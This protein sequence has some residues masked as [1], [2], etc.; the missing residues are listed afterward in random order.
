MSRGKFS[1]M[2]GYARLLAALRDEPATIS[3]F[4]A[5]HG[6]SYCGAYAYIDGL[7]QLGRVHIAR[8]EIASRIRPLAVYAFGRGTDAPCPPRTLGGRATKGG[9][10]RT[11]RAP[12]ATLI[13]LDYLLREVELHPT[14]VHGLAEVTGVQRQ[15]LRRT[16]NQLLADRLIH[17][18]EWDRSTSR[19]P[20]PAYSIGPG[21]NATRPRRATRAETNAKY[22][23][24]RAQRIRYAALHKAI[25]A[26]PSSP[27][28][29]A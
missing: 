2:R 14:T 12:S 27:Q 24:S 16:V 28:V 1:G 20:I 10:I 7:H 13:A 25:I 6:L 23:A 5:R 3:Q 11:G 26:P 15:A 18:G 22:W 29:S 4:R 19:A 21:R 8:W 17:V 9:T